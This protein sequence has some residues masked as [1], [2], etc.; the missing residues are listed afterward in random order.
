MTRYYG[1][2]QWRTLAAECIRLQP[3]CATPG[4]GQP[5]VVADHVVPRRD[6]GPDSLS[7]LRALCRDCHGQLSRGAAHP[8]AVGCDANG[9]VWD[10]E[11]WWRT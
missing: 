11:H 1:T 6:G 7:N 2:R 9:N 10:S 4:C 8:R 3:V 5:S